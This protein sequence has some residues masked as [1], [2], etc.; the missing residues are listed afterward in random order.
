[1]KNIK[2]FMSAFLVG[3]MLMST[4][5]P[6][7]A[8]TTNYTYETQAK[9][10][11]DLG[12]FKG[13]STDPSVFNPDLGSEMDRQS[14]IV[15]MLRLIG[16]E[17]DA[18]AMTDSDVNAAL[19]KFTDASKLADW[20]KKSVA[21]AI[22][23]G[24]VKGSSDTTIAPTD[25][26]L[27]KMFAALVLRNV[28]Y[29]VTATN[30][31]AAAS[32]MAEKGGLTAAEAMKFADKNLIRDDLVG[33]SFGSL[34]MAYAST[35]KSVIQTLV[36]S[37]KVDMA[38]ASSLGLV[39]SAQRIAE[40]KQTGA[41]IITV[42]FNA[43][44]DPTKVTASSVSVKKGASIVNVD[45]VTPAAD[46]KS[47]AIQMAGNLASET[48]TVSITGAATDALTTNVT[49]LEEKVT[50]LEF[51]SDKLVLFN[52][53]SQKATATYKV[54]NQYAEDITKNVSID[55]TSSVGTATA[56]EGKITVT[57]SAYFKAGDSVNI[58]AI[59]SGTN[60]FA[61]GVL[62]VADKAQVSDITISSLYNVE[63]KVMKTSSVFSNYWLV[64]EAKDQYGNKVAAGDIAADVLI[65]SSNNSIVNFQSAF[66][67][68]T[69]N[70]EEKT[71]LKLDNPS[72]TPNGGT[73][74]ITII[75][76]YTGKLASYDI[77][78]REQS[79]ADV[80]TF[81][82]PEY[83]IAGEKVKIPFTA[84][85][86]YGEEIKDAAGVLDVLTPSFSN[87]L[88]TGSFS[89]DI[90]N[91]KPI[92]TVDATAL[93]KEESV[94]ITVVT[95]TGKLAQTTVS[96]RSNAIANTIDTKDIS[97]R[98]LLANTMDIK[99]PDNIIVKDQYG[100]E[101][102]INSTFKIVATSSDVT[103]VAVSG[104]NEMN[105]SNKT[106]RLQAM[107]K[108]YATITFKVINIA[109]NKELASKTA[110]VGVVEKSDIS[111][112]EV[113]D[114]AKVYIDAGH[115][116]E[117]KVY[118]LLSD[119][120]K[121]SIPQSGNFSVVISTTPATGISFND[122]THK[123][124]A[125]NTVQF[126]AYKTTKDISAVVTVFGTK[127]TQ[128]F[129]KTVTITNELPVA[130]TLSIATGTLTSGVVQTGDTVVLAPL[131]EANT[132]A[133]LNAIVSDILVIKDQYGVKMKDISAA[134]LPSYVKV[135]ASN[136]P[137]GKV[138]DGAL[139]TALVAKT[140]YSV[141]VVTDN[142][143]TLNFEMKLD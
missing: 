9:S 25:K 112:Y 108:G 67:K 92:L 40:A 102:K 111:S 37:G 139:T 138:L 22:K 127:A 35:S 69:I 130:T 66:V 71:V 56:T 118:G 105:T 80:I 38:K 10:L 51:V 95:K 29:E 86:Q 70:G 93:T 33:M 79:K 45:K 13:V 57:N 2:K 19:A 4:M 63:N 135:Y 81:S 1:M 43:A 20:A 15:M 31:E 49:A 120:S 3:T 77:T 117:L 47:I 103:K 61:S 11:Y 85:D 99:N 55:V 109:D 64:V 132:Q 133:G 44:I 126:D 123:F 6:T 88:V 21:Y 73:A 143:K 14:G 60:T 94:L 82:A 106:I 36:D 72:G 32:T 122:T 119:G 26:F 52:G 75:S 134:S 121:V 116:K 124:E 7:F 110:T 28:G 41:K 136:L 17:A 84:I 100:R 141:T 59:H 8:A 34:K 62:T 142:G 76:K 114:V 104:T 39:S 91:G 125:D 90:V 129:T 42:K 115:A 140:G 131:A 107:G 46:N 23:N 128:V 89:Q 78:V 83:P 68:E 50:K 27:G 54:T 48:Y 12:L 53:N 30:Y 5:V 74:K 24:L 65:S 16:K 113:A 137:E 87:S 97:N 18:N 101:M 96:F 98:L 58:S